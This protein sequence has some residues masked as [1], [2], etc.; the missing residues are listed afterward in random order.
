MMALM[1]LGSAI[2][3]GAGVIKYLLIYFAS[4]ICGSLVSLYFHPNIVSAGASGALFGL[5]GCQLVMICS[6]WKQ[7]KKAQLI[8]WL[9]SYL[10]WIGLFI[11]I[12]YFF[13]L[14]DSYAHIGGL[15]G[16]VV[17]S[18]V[19]LPLNN[20]SK[21]PNLFNIGGIIALAL[22]IWQADL[23]VMHAAKANPGVKEASQTSSVRA[24][25]K[26]D[27]LPFWLPARFGD[28]A[29]TL[30]AASL[31]CP[32]FKTAKELADKEIQLDPDNGYSYYNRAMVQHK[33]DHDSEALTDVVKAIALMP[34]QY[35]FTTLK[36]RAEAGLKHYDKALGDAQAALKIEDKDHAEAKDIIG[37][38][39]LAQGNTKEAI[40][41]FNKALGDDE[42]FGAAFY[43][44]AMAHALHKDKTEAEQDFIRAKDRNY[45]PTA[46][47]KEYGPKPS[48]TE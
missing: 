31:Q 42:Q 16:G 45:V 15:A 27:K 46:W 13:P 28:P 8:G 40:S 25:L 30:G 20:E 2:E 34:H 10:I 44:R 33:F 12:G 43:H 32:D 39:K 26:A 29:E 7:M 38:C 17:A 47:D 18:L 6:Y 21:L 36:A 3:G 48:T 19:L 41:W 11:A 35:S 9:L 22:G 23:Y 5:M 37:C 4:L 1:Q 14:L 24:M